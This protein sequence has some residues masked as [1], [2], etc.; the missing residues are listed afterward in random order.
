MA[1]TTITN[2]D[3]LI[4]TSDTNPV[5]VMYFAGDNF[6]TPAGFSNNNSLVI[7]SINKLTGINS[8]APTQPLGATW[9][10]KFYV[11]ITPSSKDDYLF[12]LRADDDAKVFINNTLIING[13]GKGC[14]VDYDSVARISLDPA[15]GPYL[16]YMEFRDTGGAANLSLTYTTSKPSFT[17][18]NFLTLP[19]NSPTFGTS[20]LTGLTTSTLYM[21]KF[22][23]YVLSRT[24]RAIQSIVYCT[25][26]KRFSIDPNCLGTDAN[27][28]KGINSIYGK[29][30]VY[31]STM[32]DHCQENNLFA[33]GANDSF[34]KNP[35][36]QS[37]L[38][39]A[40]MA[41]L[42]FA[43]AITNYCKEP[44]NNI[45]PTGS[46]T[47]YCK[48]TDNLYTSQHPNSA[49]NSTYSNA[50]RAARKQS[51]ISS[52]QSAITS[53][54]INKQGKPTQDVLD[55][56]NTDYP[57]IQRI[58][59][60]NKTSD[61]IIPGVF[62]YCENVSNISEN[63]LC[64]AIYNTYKTD[65]DIVTSQ[66]KID[67]FKNGIQS[68][69]FMG[70]GTNTDHNTKYLAE[71][72]AP[73]TFAKY[74]PYAINYCAT[75]DN[76][77]SPECQLYYNNVQSNIDQMMRTQYSNPT[78]TTTTAPIIPTT[79][80][81]APIT[82]AAAPITTTA[83]P[84]IPITTP[85]ISTIAPVIPITTP[86]ISTIAPVISTIPRLN[87]ILTYGYRAPDRFSNKEQFCG[88]NSD[89]KIETSSDT[90][91]I[92]L[93]FLLFVVLVTVLTK[94]VSCKKETKSDNK[95]KLITDLEYRF[96]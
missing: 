1:S 62:P 40:P 70:K 12:R 63:P 19:V 79:T 89:D 53:T 33:T 48:T 67:N 6:T 39:N 92:F 66:Q 54:D 14:C 91:Y 24:A 13:W 32:I 37:Y 26:N 2:F 43:T 50:F 34:C 46:T 71:R 11:Y 86:I 25:T 93:L 74:L 16:L 87:P 47:S 84:I 38:M 22:S 76:V 9:C 4:N 72:D 41:S 58:L 36:Y 45:Y 80:T 55:Y 75:G 35:N 10:A 90:L 29:E 20:P 88:D 85:I 68:K 18:T 61:L 21:S 44:A 8:I 57:A 82:T 15:N 96:K 60:S 83:T 3:G 17:S 95:A 49:M 28:Y 59:P 94:W 42:N 5:L 78:S 64:N 31:S 27:Q 73:N 81:V 77:V 65:P 7:P 30:P 52:I 69:A 51:A 56:I 23:P